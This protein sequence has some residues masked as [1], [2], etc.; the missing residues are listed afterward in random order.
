MAGT[1]QTARRS[2][3][4]KAAAFLSRA[5]ARRETKSKSGGKAAVKRRYRFGT[6]ALRDI[7]KF[8]RTG[9]LLISKVPFPHLVREIAP[10]YTNSP[11]FLASAVLALQESS[12]AY[13]V[14]LFQDA[15]L[16]AIHDKR[17]T[18]M[19]KDIQLARR[20]RGQRA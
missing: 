11:H 9:E 7:S 5:A 17:V 12:E 18:V 6:V 16:C 1:K 3:G 4:G 13:L 15:Q 2:T 10:K 19:L 8:Q 14:G 20:I